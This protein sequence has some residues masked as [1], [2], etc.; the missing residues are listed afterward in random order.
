MYSILSVK[1]HFFHS[2]SFCGTVQMIRFAVFFSAMIRNDDPQNSC[3]KKLANKII[4]KIQKEILEYNEWLKE[5][6]TFYERNKNCDDIDNISV[7]NCEV[8]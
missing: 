7:H 8:F 6:S 1:S 2:N 5:F 3:H 4:G